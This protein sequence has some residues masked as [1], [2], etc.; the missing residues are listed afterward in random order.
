MPD[1]MEQ[2]EAGKKLQEE[3]SIDVNSLRTK[4][5]F[6][7]ENAEEKPKQKRG[8]KKKEIPQQEINKEMDPFEQAQQIIDESE[9]I[10]KEI[11]NNQEQKPEKYPGFNFND[12][13]EKG[14]KIFYIRIHEKLGVKELLE[15]KLRTIYP[16]MLVGV[17][18]KSHAV[19]IGP[20]TKD[21][22]FMKRNDAVKAYNAINIKIIENINIKDELGNLE[23]KDMEN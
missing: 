23:I 19:C 14:Q 3:N 15:L 7:E 8:R 22:I 6:T 13:Y 5:G 12:Y 11:K 4:I 21:R 16:K 9:N 2:L 18:E 10:K 20:E 17:I 1:I